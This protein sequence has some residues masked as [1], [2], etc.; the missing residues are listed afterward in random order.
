MNGEQPMG[1]WRGRASAVREALRVGSGAAAAPRIS[2][3]DR[4]RPRWSPHPRPAFN[5]RTMELWGRFAGAVRRALCCLR[6]G[7]LPL[8]AVMLA[9][10]LLASPAF[11]QKN[12]LESKCPGCGV[13]LTQAVVIHRASCRS[14]ATNDCMAAAAFMKRMIAAREVHAY[15]VKE[16]D[17]LA[18]SDC[19]HLITLARN[20]GFKTAED[21]QN[22]REQA[23]RQAE[24][25]AWWRDFQA[26][27]K[28][29][30]NRRQA[31]RDR[32]DN[33]QQQD[34]EGR[35]RAQEIEESNVAV[36]KALLRKHKGNPAA[37]ENVKAQLRQQAETAEKNAAAARDAGF[38][39]TASGLDD[40]AHAYR[41]L[42]NSA[43]E[44][45]FG[46]ELGVVGGASL[47]DSLFGNGRAIGESMGGGLEHVADAEEGGGGRFGRLGGVAR[48]M[49]E[50]SLSDP[51]QVYGGVDPIGVGIDNMDSI[52]PDDVI[53]STLVAPVRTAGEGI[54]GVLESGFARGSEAAGGGAPT[55]R[56]K[57]SC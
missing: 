7:N 38:Y 26:R 1:L 24:N 33:L 35:Q 51:S 47:L 6:R 37:L 16:I 53:R 44:E 25:D 54:L 20:R 45:D 57:G 52:W 34:N 31:E 46:S 4:P 55:T 19:R 27:S 22:E 28:A 2:G 9:M 32:E 56:Q 36:A 5:S 3:T 18:K 13:D 15:T 41:E 21:L 17:T 14:D 8:G 43:D 10:C 23:R 40:L 11:A 49:F 39:Q 42:A 29:D 50:D 30:E 12:L 48:G